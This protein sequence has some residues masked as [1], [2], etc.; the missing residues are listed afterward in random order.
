MEWGSKVS[1]KLNAAADLSLPCDTRIL[2][3]PL[4]PKGRA[5]FTSRQRSPWGSGEWGLGGCSP[6]ARQRH[7]AQEGGRGFTLE[8][9]GDG[10][11]CLAGEGRAV[12]GAKM[13]QS[14][15][16][17]CLGNPS[18]ADPACHPPSLWPEAPGPGLICPRRSLPG[19]GSAS[20]QL[21]VSPRSGVCSCSLQPARGCD[22][23]QPLAPDQPTK[24]C[25]S[26]CPSTPLHLAHPLTWV[27]RGLFVSPQHP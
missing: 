10:Q 6:T 5:F 27:R 17:R 25:L 11:L 3:A 8:R 14:T 16:T 13:P 21:G 19:T 2:P 7:Q 26:V 4:A 23:D 9:A 22:S 20:A 12:P 18:K 15:P 1:S 24:A